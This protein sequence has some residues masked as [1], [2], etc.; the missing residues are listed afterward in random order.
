M[1]WL[2]PVVIKG[3]DNKGLRVLWC[4]LSTI[5]HLK[6]PISY[7][8]KKW[9]KKHAVKNSVENCSFSI[10]PY[11]TIMKN[12][13]SQKNAKRL[14]ELFRLVNTCWHK[15]VSQNEDTKNKS[16]HRWKIPNLGDT[17]YGN[18]PFYFEREKE[19]RWKQKSLNQSDGF[20]PQ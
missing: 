11:L 6:C 5:D 15:T 13:L 14:S 20:I 4:N 12:K 2:I 19:N 7:L 17:F 18:K 10:F 8:M 3:S 1:G 16:I 9:G